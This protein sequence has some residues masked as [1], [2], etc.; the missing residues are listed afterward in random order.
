[1]SA[2]TD[3]ES[4]LRLFGRT[5]SITLAQQPIRDGFIGKNSGFFESVGNAIEITDLRVQFEI[6]KNL[7]KEPNSCTVTVSNL[8]GDTRKAL[9]RK[10]VYAIVRAGYDGVTRLLFSGNVSYNPSKHEKTEWETKFSIAD[11]GRAFA[12]ARMN[13]SYKPPISVQQVLSDAAASMGLKLPSEVEQSQE[14][15]SALATGLCCH[16]PTRDI[17]TR[18]LAPYGFGWSV[19]NGRLQIISDDQIIQGR[20]IVLDTTKGQEVG[21]VINTPELSL[22][23]RPGEASELTVET[24]LY[25]EIMPA[26][27]IDLTSESASGMFRVQELT[28]AGDTHGPDW[29]TTVKAFRFGESAKKGKRKR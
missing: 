29:K 19:Q 21:G 15:K 27:S 16:G 2:S 13:R 4:K 22:P 25:P 6:K 10:P 5:V 8:S 26:G 20:A 1:M 7:G 3:A 18:Q 11:G 17:L 23:H 9:Q 28:H 12:H 24:L 14:L